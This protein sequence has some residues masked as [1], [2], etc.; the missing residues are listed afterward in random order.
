M[1]GGK[2]VFRKAGSRGIQTLATIP[3][4][5]SGAMVGEALAQRI[6]D[7]KV[8]MKE[9]TAE[10]MGEAPSTAVTVAST[11]VT[12]TKGTYK[13]NGEFN[14]KEELMDVLKTATN[15]E[16][17]S[18]NIQITDDV[19]VSDLQRKRARGAKI[20]KNIP[21]EIQGEAR[22]EAVRLEEERISIKE[23]TDGPKSVAVERKLADIDEKLDRIYSGETVTTE[24]VVEE[25]AL[26]EEKERG[27]FGK[28]ID[29]VFKK[30][31]IDED[32]Q[33]TE[34]QKEQGIQEFYDEGV[35]QEDA[36]MK[37]YEEEG[38]TF[39]AEL[40]REELEKIKSE[41]PTQYLERKL[42]VYKRAP[43]YTYDGVKEGK[44]TDIYNKKEA[45]EETDRIYQLEKLLGIT[46]TE[47]EVKARQEL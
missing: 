31:K 24:E 25:A 26:V 46:P 42:E 4:E 17:S 33:L 7:G 28:I 9:V 41:S 2:Y 29:K 15:D 8:D 10:A 39:F 23:T 12:P 3:I 34:E 44:R 45:Q 36:F 40:Q 27:F 21:V 14:T 32:V 38:D 5:M 20:E 11:M 35:K 18:M 13:I 43:Q 47:Q 6:T 37:R 30:E 19:E 16:L 22:E 1:R